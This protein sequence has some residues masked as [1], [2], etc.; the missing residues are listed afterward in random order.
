VKYRLDKAFIICFETATTTLSLSTSY[1]A[2]QE[3]IAPYIARMFIYK[4]RNFMNSTENFLMVNRVEVDEVV[5]GGKE[6]GK[7]GRNYDSKIKKGHGS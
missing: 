1:L 3:G 6:D 7:V 5:V 2:K 4:V